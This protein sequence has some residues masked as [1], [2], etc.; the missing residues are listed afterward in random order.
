M[1]GRLVEADGSPQ[2]PMAPHRPLCFPC[3]SDF[4]ITYGKQEAMNVVIQVS[5]FSPPSC[6]LPPRPQHV[7]LGL[8]LHLR[9]PKTLLKQHSPCVAASLQTFAETQASIAD[10]RKEGRVLNGTEAV[11]LATILG[12]VDPVR[13]AASSCKA[14]RSP[15][16]CVFAHLPFA[17]HQ[18][19]SVVDPSPPVGDGRKMGVGAAKF[20]STDRACFTS[21]DKFCAVGANMK[22]RG[23]HYEATRVFRGRHG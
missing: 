2:P 22:V 4:P 9:P 5:R 8:C 7:F 6:L 14:T 19:P 18:T 23:G 20:R 16:P 1:L 15:P 3:C 11:V 12:S 10:P 21:D 13:P 17:S